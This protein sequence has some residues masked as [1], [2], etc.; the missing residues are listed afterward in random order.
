[1]FYEPFPWNGEL[2][3]G[4]YQRGKKKTQWMG[5]KEKVFLEDF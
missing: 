2:C 3:G 5:L 1:M 4:F